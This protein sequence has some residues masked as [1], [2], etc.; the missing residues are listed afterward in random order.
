[1]MPQLIKTGSVCSEGSALINTIKR[2]EGLDLEE[3]Q[4]QLIWRKIKP[5]RLLELQHS[6]G[7]YKRV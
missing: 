7:R 1:M 3:I 6:H 5:Q 2:E 4:T